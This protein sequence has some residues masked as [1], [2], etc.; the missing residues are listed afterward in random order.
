MALFTSSDRVVAPCLKTQFIAIEVYENGTLKSRDTDS[1][2]PDHPLAEVA[3]G[4]P[5]CK[6]FSREGLQ[7]QE[8]TRHAPAETP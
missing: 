8:I 1:T 5:L 2:G 7:P 6:R 3:R 4:E